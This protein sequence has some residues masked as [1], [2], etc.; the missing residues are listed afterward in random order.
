MASGESKAFGDPTSG[1]G[2]VWY[3]ADTMRC[4]RTGAPIAIIESAEE[5]FG[6]ALGRS[7]PAIHFEVG[8]GEATVPK[9]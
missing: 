4:A 6:R 1:D 2:A 7:L 9:P 8:G 5:W 3:A